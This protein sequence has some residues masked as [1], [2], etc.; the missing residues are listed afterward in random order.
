MGFTSLSSWVPCKRAVCCSLQLF[1][2]KCFCSS[3]VRAEDRVVPASFTH[4][5]PGVGLRAALAISGEQELVRCYNSETDEIELSFNYLECDMAHDLL[6]VPDEFLL[7]NVAGCPKQEPPRFLS[8]LRAGLQFLIDNP[9]SA[10][11]FANGPVRYR[12][13]PI[14]AWVKA[15]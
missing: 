7:E 4:L 2:K 13:G 9:D 12:R 8:T 6:Q 10:K 14:G 11:T 3:Y 5:G 1:L 15:K